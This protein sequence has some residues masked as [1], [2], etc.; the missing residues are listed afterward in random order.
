MPHKE[1]MK[2]AQLSAQ[3]TAKLWREKKLKSAELEDFFIHSLMMMSARGGIF[4]NLNSCIA[5]N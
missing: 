3:H 1:S 5:W 4:L 2:C